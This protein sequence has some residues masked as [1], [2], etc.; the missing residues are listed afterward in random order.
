MSSPRKHNAEFKAEVALAAL[1]GEETTAQL[2]SRYGVHATMINEWRRS[3]MTRAGELFG[4]HQKMHENAEAKVNELYRQIGQ[5]KV[6]NDFLSKGLSRLN[7][8]GG[9][10]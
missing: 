2:S 5:L 6:E 4:T 8:K 1:R 10:R 3:L 9:V 7:W